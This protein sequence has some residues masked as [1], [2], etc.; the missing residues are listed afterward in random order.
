MK[1]AARKPARAATKTS[2]TTRD[3]IE[4]SIFGWIIPSWMRASPDRGD[5]S[6]GAT[7]VAE[8]KKLKAGTVFRV[9]L[10]R[11]QALDLR[12]PGAREA[13]QDLIGRLPPFGDRL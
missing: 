4:S 3:R 8:S 9:G 7:L 12:K 1:R 2:T 6:R 10:H 13:G 5:I 11:P